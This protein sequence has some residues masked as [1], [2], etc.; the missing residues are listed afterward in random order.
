MLTALPREQ[1]QRYHVSMLR[2][3]YMPVLLLRAQFTANIIEAYC[4]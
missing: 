4:Y 2:Y 1:Y 3:L